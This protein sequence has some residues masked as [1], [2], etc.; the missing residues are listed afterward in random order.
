MITINTIK[1]TDHYHHDQIKDVREPDQLMSDH[2]NV[3]PAD[4]DHHYD[5]DHHVKHDMI[6][7]IIIMISR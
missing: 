6:M 1:N 3:Y 7:M 5:D 4:I 2:A